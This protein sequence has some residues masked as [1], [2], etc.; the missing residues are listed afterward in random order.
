VEELPVIRPKHFMA[1]EHPR[2]KHANLNAAELGIMRR[3]YQSA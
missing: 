2:S 3:E 1:L